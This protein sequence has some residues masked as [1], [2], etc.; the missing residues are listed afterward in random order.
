VF[1][2]FLGTWLAVL[3]AILAAFAAGEGFGLA[4][5][6]II[7]DF[8]HIFV[9]SPLLWATQDMASADAAAQGEEIVF[10]P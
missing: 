4:V 10:L 2:P 1:I 5:A 8:I 7:I 9:F 6:A 3:V